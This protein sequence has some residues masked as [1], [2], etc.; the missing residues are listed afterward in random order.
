MDVATL[1]ARRAELLIVDVGVP[2][3]GRSAGSTGL[4]SSRST[5]SRSGSTTSPLI[6]RSSQSVGAATEALVPWRAG[7]VAGEREGATAG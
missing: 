5:C 2:T 3:G 7:R 4:C 1:A 6:N